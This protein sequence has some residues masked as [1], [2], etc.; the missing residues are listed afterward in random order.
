[1]RIE[2]AASSEH[3]S[4][5]LVLLQGS[6]R[7]FERMLGEVLQEFA[8]GFGTVKHLARN[9]SDYLIAVEIFLRHAGPEFHHGSGCNIKVTEPEVPVR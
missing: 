9:E 2:V 8:E 7:V 5:E 1:M 3:F 4:G 6:V